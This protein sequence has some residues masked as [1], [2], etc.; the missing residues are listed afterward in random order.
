MK[1]VTTIDHAAGTARIEITLERIE[2]GGAA[3]NVVTGV[4]E[5][6]WPGIEF[7]D[8]PGD[9]ETAPEAPDNFDAPAPAR[10]PKEKRKPFDHSKAPREGSV[11]ARVLA[12]C[13]RLGTADFHK[14]ADE[15]DLLTHVA[16][17]AIANLRK[18]G[19]IQ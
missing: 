10:A 4:C 16:A 17:C 18:G 1:A 15:L 3:V 6:L 9:G 8:L 7:T 12:A 19:H 2:D 11:S 5:C 13:K 14:I